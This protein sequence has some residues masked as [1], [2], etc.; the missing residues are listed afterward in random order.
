MRKALFATLIATIALLSSSFVSA[1]TTRP[2]VGRMMIVSIDGCRPDLLL[3]ADTPVIHALL[4][5][6]T[7]TFW[8]RTTPQAVTLPSH[9]SM[10]TGVVPRKHEVEWDKDLPFSQPVYP[11]VPM[12]FEVAHRAGLST[13]MAAGKSK[14]VVFNKPG[15]LDCCWLPTEPKVKDASVVDHAVE[16]IRSNRPEVLFVHLAGVDTAGHKYGWASHEQLAAIHEADAQIGRLLKTLEETGLRASTAVLITADHGGGGLMHGGDDP[17]S[18]YIPWILTGPGV[19]KDLD[20]TTYGKTVVDTEDTFCTACYLLGLPID[21]QVD[22][23]PILEALE[24]PMEL[25]RAAR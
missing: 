23:K 22:G 17:R 3:R 1:Q 9:A 7:F 4:P 16:M 6:S 5:E 10:L 15:T 25:M 2:T 24:T 20:L 14:F 19:R 21:P 18:R 11:S 8:A 13:G 12:L